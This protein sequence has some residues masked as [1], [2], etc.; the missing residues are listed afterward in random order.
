MY[1]A[2]V[3]YCLAENVKPI[4]NTPFSKLMMY[5]D[6]EKRTDTHHK[7]YWKNCSLIDEVSDGEEETEETEDVEVDM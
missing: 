1:N 3:A 7:T 5:N 4:G 6:F 2:Y